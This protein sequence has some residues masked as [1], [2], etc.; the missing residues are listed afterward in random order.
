[1]HVE[2]MDY[3]YARLSTGLAEQIQDMKNGWRKSVINLSIL[4]YS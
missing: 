2:Y 3:K 4:G 1:M